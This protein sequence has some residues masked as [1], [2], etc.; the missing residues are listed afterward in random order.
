MSS[1]KTAHVCSK[2]R[3]SLENSNNDNIFFLLPFE[4]HIYNLERLV[5]F[6][7]LSI[8]AQNVKGVL[9][10]VLMIK[11]TDSKNQINKSQK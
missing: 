7:S 3:D 10:I 1:G 11:P 2:I 4:L 5:I 9:M 8:S 6:L